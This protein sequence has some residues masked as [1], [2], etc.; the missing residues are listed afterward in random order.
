MCPVIDSLSHSTGLCTKEESEAFCAKSEA[1]L[2]NYLDR[3]VKKGIITP[4]ERKAVGY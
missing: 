1:A 3:Q 4:D 2:K